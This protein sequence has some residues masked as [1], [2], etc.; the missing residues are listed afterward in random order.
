MRFGFGP[1]LSD[2]VET[3]FGRRFFFVSLAPPR[4]RIV[5]AGTPANSACLQSTQN[6]V[7]QTARLRTA[8]QHRCTWARVARS[9]RCSHVAAVAVTTHLPMRAQSLTTSVPAFLLALRSTTHANTIVQHQ[10][11]CSRLGLVLDRSARAAHAHSDPASPR[12]CHQGPGPSSPLAHTRCASKRSRTRVFS[13]RSVQRWPR[14][15]RTRDRREQRANGH[16]WRPP[17]GNFDRR[18]RIRRQ[19]HDPIMPCRHTSDSQVVVAAGP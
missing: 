8:V 17:G 1:R 12:S 7:L 15:T 13:G 10:D 3:S 14:K 2:G 5:P 6:D 18:P 16:E 9:H 4:V 11:A 19:N